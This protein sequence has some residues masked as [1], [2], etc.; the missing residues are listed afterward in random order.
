MPPKPDFTKAHRPYEFGVK[1]SLASTLHRSAGG[2]FIAHAKA[3][4]TPPAPLSAAKLGAG[5]HAFGSHVGTLFFGGRSGDPGANLKGQ[6]NI[7][8]YTFQ[9]GHTESG[10]SAPVAPK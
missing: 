8:S 3:L 7:W 9:P 10:S 4:P 1:V 5:Y 6:G 2:Q